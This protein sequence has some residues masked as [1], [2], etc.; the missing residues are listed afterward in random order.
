MCAAVMLVSAAALL[1]P[2]QDSNDGPVSCAAACVE[3]PAISIASP[4]LESYM[5]ISFCSYVTTVSSFAPRTV[6]FL[7]QIHNQSVPA[8]DSVAQDRSLEV[9]PE[10]MAD[11]FVYALER[12]MI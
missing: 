7:Q 9:A 12:I 4:A 11:Y 3:I 8:R 1:V 5:E 6:Q 2:H 10:R